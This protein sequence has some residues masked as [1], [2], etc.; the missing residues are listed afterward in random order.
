MFK[1]KK[2]LILSL[3][4][5]ILI[6]GIVSRF[7]VSTAKAEKAKAETPVSYFGEMMVSGNRI[8]G[9]KTNAPVQVMGMSFFWSN[10]SEKYWNAVTVDRMVDE[11]KCEIVR[12]AYGVDDQGNPYNPANEE[13]VREVV[14]AA[15]NRGIYVIIDWHSHGAYLNPSAA[16]DFFGKM[17]GEF[18]GYDNVIFE[19][20]NEPK[21][22]PWETVKS[23]AEQVIPVIRAH[24][25]NLIVVGTPTWSQ[26]VDAA[27]NNPINAQN[28][29]YALHF[30][31][32]AHKQ[33]LRDK[34]NYA[35]QKGLALFVT[36]W[37]S[38]GSDGNGGIDRASTAEWLDWMYQNKISSCNWAINDKDEASSIFNGSGLTEAG[39]LLKDIFEGHS[40][41]AEWRKEEG[42]GEG[43][44]TA[45]ITIKAFNGKYVCADIN[46]Q[47]TLIGD[48]SGADTWEKYEKVDN[49]DGT[50]SFCSQANNKY[51]CAEKNQ[52][53]KLIARSDKIDTW[54][55]FKVIDMG[56]KNIALLALSTNKYVCCDQDKGY[57]LYANRSNPST[58]EIFTLSDPCPSPSPSPSP[59]PGSGSVLKGVYKIICKCSGKVLDVKDISTVDGAKMQQWTAGNGDNQKF[60]VEIQ[61]DGYYKITARHSGKVLDVPSAT[62]NS[63]VQLQ[64]YNDNGSDAQRWEIVDA[65]NGYYK[66]ISKTS[67]LLMGVA[68]ASTADG[69]VVQQGIDN[70][71]DAQRWSFALDSDDPNPVSPTPTNP[72]SGSIYSISAASIPN[73][74]GNGVVSVKFMNGTNGAYADKDIYWGVIG[75]RLN[76]DTFCYLDS[77]G[78]LVPLSKA[79]NDAAGHLTKNGVN[80]ANIYHKVSETSWVN[81]PKMH[82]GRIFLSVGSPCYI[83]TYDDG[84][85]GPD[86]NNPTDPNRDVYFDFVEFTFND[87]GY[88]GNTTR[89]DQFG[90]PIQNR[91]V[92]KAGNYDKT[93]GELESETRAGLFAK[94]QNEVPKEFKS[95]GTLQAPYRI[96]CPISGPFKA[97]GE[98][99][100]YFSSYSGISTRD[101]FLGIGGA[102]NEQTCA[103]LNRHIYHDA[104]NWNNVGKYYQAGPANYYAKFWHD[105]SIDGLAYGFCYDDV[106]NQSPTLAVADP[107]GLI[108]R[109]GW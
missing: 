36:E 57:V 61:A 93:V 52:D 17:A 96:V 18:G 2:M 3:A 20:Y 48:R 21:Q 67:K 23:Y 56:N 101:I 59:S 7:C 28:I 94:Y 75:K 25:N 33:F 9:S 55:K 106:N 40:K 97:G 10:W 66:I 89:V 63:G 77:S 15:I 76:T 51:V 74:N 84:F 91:L 104:A 90:F 99:A 81:L 83:K 5:S 82:S 102:A 65:G 16:K 13:K 24:S 49:N 54:E 80:Y 88:N 14:K 103:A 37:G 58:W 85:A 95:L 109:I 107:K 22:I 30:Y 92:N 53:G 70:G 47:G 38:C 42:G 39:Y 68:N 69:A 19:L 32:G 4:L 64:Q 108:I 87:G 62:S 35:L 86:I 41:V 98:Y 73:P 11:F 27:A 79:L 44:E 34:G 72:T 8:N 6:V 78:N 26:D 31:A 46:I 100:N 43:E 1:N 50:V 45:G 71:S 12:A 60:S 29:A 105:H